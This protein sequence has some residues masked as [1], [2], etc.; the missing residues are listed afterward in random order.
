[1]F[2][3]PSQAF[4]RRKKLFFAGW[5]NRFA[6][7]TRKLAMPLDSIVQAIFFYAPDAD[8]TFCLGASGDQMPVHRPMVIWTQCQAVRRFVI[9]TYD[10]RDEMRRLSQRRRLLKQNPDSAPRTPEIVYFQNCFQLISYAPHPMR[11]LPQNQ[12]SRK[13][14]RSVRGNPTSSIC[15]SAFSYSQQCT[16]P[17]RRMNPLPSRPQ[18]LFGSSVQ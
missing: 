17:L 8:R 14:L 9:S 16:T 3:A 12:T 13:S 6:C 2:F 18:N 10:K 1:M 15:D 11:H 7:D 5:N 4:Y